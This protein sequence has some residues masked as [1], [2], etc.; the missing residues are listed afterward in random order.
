MIRR[1]PRSTLFPYTTLF[2]S[3]FLAALARHAAWGFRPHRLTLR[4][5]HSAA[6]RVAAWGLN[7]PS[8]SAL[9]LRRGIPARRR[10][11]NVGRVAPPGALPC[12]FKAVI[13]KDYGSAGR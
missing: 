9:R 12:F 1:P 3:G 4:R 8:R 6:R 5:S 2:R 7:L 10:P 13:G 11:E